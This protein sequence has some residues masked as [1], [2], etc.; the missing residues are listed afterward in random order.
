VRGILVTRQKF[1]RKWKAIAFS[2]GTAV[3][4]TVALAPSSQAAAG[5]FEYYTAER[6]NFTIVNPA[7][8]TCLL[9]QYAVYA[10]NRTDQAIQ[11]YDGPDCQTFLGTVG[12]GSE[13]RR[14]FNSIKAVS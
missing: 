14:N 11:V 5:D 4:L 6:T 7:P 1:A 9:A 13:F 10:I 3:F 8:G 2:A 12:S